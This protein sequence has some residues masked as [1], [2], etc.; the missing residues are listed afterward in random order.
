MEE[1]CCSEYV[2]SCRQVW[3][4]SLHNAVSRAE[5]SDRHVLQYICDD[6]VAI[7]I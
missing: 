7:I 1:Q 5:A 6:K 4:T 3:C 2:Q